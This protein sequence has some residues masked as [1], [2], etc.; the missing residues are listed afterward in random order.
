[1]E[2]LLT[3]L[4]LYYNYYIFYSFYNGRRGNP[5][6]EEFRQDGEPQRVTGLKEVVRV[7]PARPSDNYY[8]FYSSFNERSELY[9]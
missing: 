9:D 1:M 4:L 8:I 5:A 2:G 3:G 6:Q 7:H